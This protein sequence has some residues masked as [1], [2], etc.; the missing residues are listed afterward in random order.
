MSAP[1]VT[2]VVPTVDRV[3]LLRRCLRGLAGQTGAPPYDVVVVHDGH[4]GVAELVDEC[5]ATMP[6]R[7]L[8]VG[9]RGVSAKRNA[10]WQAARSDLVAFTDDDCEPTP[11]WLAGMVTVAAAGHDLVAGPV[12]PHPDDADVTGTFARTIEQRDDVGFFPGC[13]LLA[14]REAL[15]GVGG[16]DPGLRAGEDTDLAWRLIE[17]GARRGWADDGVVFHAVRVVSFADHLRSLP[18]WADLALVVRRH[19]QLRER[20][21]HR[22]WFWKSTHPVA[23]LAAAG[24]LLAPVD[25]RAAVAA[26][27]LVAR[28]VRAHGVRAGLAL[29]VSDVA[30]VAVVAAGSVRHGTVLL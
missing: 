4:P 21:A 17:A 12:L 11:G 9:E 14:R 3:A 10:G 8:R 27:P 30:E 25:A 23:C 6:V 20:L 19:P 18:R 26:A 15:T 5:A 22:R 28:R 13:N 16:F 2:V 29:A 24:L 1:T 7:G